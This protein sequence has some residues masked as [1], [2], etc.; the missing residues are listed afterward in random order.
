MRSPAASFDPGPRSPSPAAAAL[1]AL[2]IAALVLASVEA[3]RP[4]AGERPSELAGKARG[5]NVWLLSLDTVRAD[6]LNSYGY[7]VRETTRRL[8]GLIAHGARFERAM[9]PRAATWPSLGSVL[10]GLYPSAHGLVDNG[11]LFPDEIVTLPQIL[12]AEGYQT[13]AFLANM[14]EANHRGWD[15]LF[16]ARTVDTRIRPAV[17]EWMATVDPERPFLLWTHYFASHSPYTT[18][19]RLAERELDPGYDGP[20][21]PGK[22]ALERI[23]RE[24]IPLSEADLFHLDALYDGALVETDLRVARLGGRLAEAGLLENTIVVILADHG[25]DLYQHHGYLFH[26]CSVYQTSLQVPLAIVAP[27]VVP[28]ELEV[29]QVVELLDVLPTLLELLGLQTPGE[30]QGRSLVPALDPALEL[31]ERPAFSE[32]GHS[33]ARTVRAGDWTMVVNPDLARPSCVAGGPEDFYAIEAEEL[34]DLASDPLEQRNL[35][36]ERPQRAAELEAAIDA[37]F[38]LLPGDVRRQELPEEVKESLRA[39]GYVVD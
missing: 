36:D 29:D 13:G 6:R 17:E 9:A 15:R 5:W 32:Y 24:R 12:H 25:E 14:C 11:Y 18:G 3:W 8:D 10:T 35:A 28:E 1:F 33:R 34:Y 39:L 2:A 30:L 31:A 21:R 22:G 26:G 16:C 27:G 23:M 7:A 37:R 19:R 38:E 4:R 20:V